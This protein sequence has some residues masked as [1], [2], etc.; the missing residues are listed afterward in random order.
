MVLIVTNMSIGQHKPVR[1]EDVGCIVAEGYAGYEKIRDIE[2]FNTSE[3]PMEGSPEL[4]QILD[5]CIN[6]F[7]DYMFIS[8]GRSDDIGDADNPHHNGQRIRFVRI[9]RK[10]A[11]L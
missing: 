6:V 7:E 4:Y 2:R 1:S 5:P 11:G 10:K 9:D 3:D 8:F